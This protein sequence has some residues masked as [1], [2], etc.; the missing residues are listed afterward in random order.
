MIRPKNIA[1]TS[2]ILLAFIVFNIG[3]PVV[4]SLC[5]MEME[6]FSSCCPQPMEAAEGNHS[7]SNQGGECCASYVAAERN[8][9][10]FV[11]SH[12]TETPQPET[13]G[14]LNPSLLNGG[15]LEVSSQAL[16]AIAPILQESPP[17]LFLLHSALLI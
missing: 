6:N 15:T 13:V 12:R 3:L 10:P 7:F 17:S 14:F 11:G 8:T 9:T 16:V 5:P 4:L 1:S 2:I